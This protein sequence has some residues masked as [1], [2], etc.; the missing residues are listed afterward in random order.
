MSRAV[1]VWGE[2]QQYGNTG[3]IRKGMPHFDAAFDDTIGHDTMEHLPGGMKH[4]AIADEM[5][6]LGVRLYLRVESGWWYCQQYFGDPVE[7][8][9]GEVQRQLEYIFH[10]RTPEPGAP[11]S[12]P[13]EEE[14]GEEMELIIKQA[15]LGGVRLFN[16][17]W[18]DDPNPL[19]INPFGPLAKNMAD[20][21]RV[22]VRAGMQRWNRSSGSF[23]DA[24]ILMESLG[25]KVKSMG[26]HHEEGEELVVEINEA[27]M[28]VHCYKR[29]LSDIYPEY[30]A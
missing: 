12:V 22:G 5:M 30:P 26:T 25:K 15:T 1:F 18:Q 27:R 4:G 24:A 3:W 19:V 17:E 11:R 14:I 16:R 10:D 29:E 6:A 23:H 28:R 9:A 20:W 8:W 21:M 13:T 7:T 2:D